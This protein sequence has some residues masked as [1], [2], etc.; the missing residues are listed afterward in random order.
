[1]RSNI[2]MSCG[3]AISAKTARV[4][5][6]APLE[7]TFNEARGTSYAGRGNGG[8][9]YITTCAYEGDGAA[10][11]LYQD[12]GTLFCTSLGAQ[13]DHNLAKRFGGGVYAGVFNSNGAPV[14]LA[15][16]IVDLSSQ[17]VRSNAA[18]T[19]VL[20]A[21]YWADPSQIAAENVNGPVGT[22]LMTP[23][24][25]FNYTVVEGSNPFRDI[26]IY[27][28]NSINI[29]GS[30]GFIPGSLYAPIVVQ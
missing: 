23:V 28:T 21:G 16:T 2:A 11:T 3:G 20:V 18:Y 1:M 27:S 30:P 5:A 17:F 29:Y 10:A 15:A 6:D 8:A 25:G 22:R 13:F 26:G 19:P 24:L 7:V 4:Q 9:A 12:D 14:R